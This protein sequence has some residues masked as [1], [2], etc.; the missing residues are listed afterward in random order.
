[1]KITEIAMITFATA[2]QNE[3]TKIFPVTGHI[4]LPSAWDDIS[5]LELSSCWRDSGVPGNDDGVGCLPFPQ[6]VKRQWKHLRERQNANVHISKP[7]LESTLKPM[8]DSALPP[9]L[10]W[11]A[12]S[13]SYSTTL[14]TPNWRLPGLLLFLSQILPPQTMPKSNGHTFLPGKTG[15]ALIKQKYA[16]PGECFSDNRVTRWSICF[17]IKL[18]PSLPLLWHTKQM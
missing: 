7:R 17:M 14:L 5:F 8:F 15:T 6:S 12:S 10:I 16:Q 18:E 9:S 4:L 1:M 3:L 2:Q 11:M 13:A